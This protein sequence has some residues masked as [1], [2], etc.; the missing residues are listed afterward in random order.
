[1]TESRIRVQDDWHCTLFYTCADLVRAG[2]P[3]IPFLCL[4]WK[5]N[6]NHLSARSFQFFIPKSIG[7]ILGL[8]KIASPSN[9]LQ[10]YQYGHFGAKL[11][12]WWRWWHHPTQKILSW[13]WW[14]FSMRY[15]LSYRFTCLFDWCTNQKEGWQHGPRVSQNLTITETK[16]CCSWPYIPHHFFNSGGPLS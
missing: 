4:S 16:L 12:F 7:I 13:N 9:P 8:P 5:L 1:M 11:A 6:E 2:Q 15:F 3:R 10:R 14:K